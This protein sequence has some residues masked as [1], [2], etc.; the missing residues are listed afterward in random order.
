M[1]GLEVELDVKCLLNIV[2]QPSVAPK[3]SIALS[4]PT[5]HSGKA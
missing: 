4:F 5:I 2:C 1:H 3:C